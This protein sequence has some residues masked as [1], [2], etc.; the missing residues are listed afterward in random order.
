MRSCRQGLGIGIA[1]DGMRLFIQPICTINHVPLNVV[2]TIY[3]RSD[4]WL[5]IRFKKI[6]GDFFSNLKCNAVL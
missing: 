1:W 5:I 4:G 6:T 2:I 3:V